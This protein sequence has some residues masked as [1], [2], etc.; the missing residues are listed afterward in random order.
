MVDFSA[1]TGTWY[2]TGVQLETGTSA[3]SFE[4]ISFHENQSMCMRYYQKS[5]NVETAPGTATQVGAIYQR[6]EAGANV[7]NRC[8]PMVLP[9]NMSKSPTCTTYSI[10][11][12]SGSVSDCQTGYGQQSSV[13]GL[14]NGTDGSAA[15]SKITL[16]AG[17]DDII[18]FHYTLEA[19]LA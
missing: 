19:E 17:R 8:V 11:G 16:G 1:Q 2:L 4:H 6:H 14:F 18:G 13:T 9:V 10:N 12:Q 7:S 15:L 5:Y 3:T